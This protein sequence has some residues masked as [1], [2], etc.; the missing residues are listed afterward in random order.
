MTGAAACT[1]AA[2]TVR[3]QR[4]D[5]THAPL[6]MAIVNCTPDSFSDGGVWAGESAVAHAMSCVRA[7]AS[8]VDIG[9]ESTRPG[10]ERVPAVE[11]VRRTQSVVCAL[12]S[13]LRAEGRSDVAISI[14][15]TRAA[16]AHAAFD[17][18]A[19]I[20]NDV[21]ACTE[22][23][24][25]AP[26]AASEGAGLVLMHRVLPPEQDRWSHER[27]S[28]IIEGEVVRAVG[29]ALQER[30]ASVQAC[31]VPLGAIAIDPG[32]G[33]GKTVDQNLALV[34][35]LRALAAMGHPVVVGASR[36]SF[37]GAVTGEADPARRDA[38]SI[39]VHLRAA[40]AGAA[41]LRVHEVPGHMQAL[42]VWRAISAR[43]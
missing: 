22:D 33:F 14:D 24:Q 18:G 32:L 20:V 27:A 23:P 42:R 36:K 35:G 8:I 13:W 37:V 30:I 11:Q 12:S 7:G 10:A 43:G 40:D 29:A 15:T 26:L 38:G 9:G 31:G 4:C 39:A 19:Q 21:S 6:I 25:L 17:A 3:G 28:S 34:A 41:V 16:V 1:A 2:W 5:L